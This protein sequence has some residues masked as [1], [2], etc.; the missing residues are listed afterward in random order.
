MQEQPRI[1]ARFLEE[2]RVDVDL[3]YDQKRAFEIIRASRDA[4]DRGAWR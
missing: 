4:Y 2:K 1:P 3:F